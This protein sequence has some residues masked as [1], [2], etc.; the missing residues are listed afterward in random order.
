MKIIYLLNI[1]ILFAACGISKNTYIA[2][3]PNTPMFSK[4]KEISVNTA[5]SPTHIELQGAISA[6]KH[7]GITA[8]RFYGGSNRKSNEL[9]INL[10]TKIKKSFFASTTIGYGNTKINIF[11]SIP[12]F[13]DMDKYNSQINYT[14]WF[15]HPGV[16]IAKETEDITYKLG[17]SIK[18]GFNAVKSYEYN[19]EKMF[20]GRWQYSFIQ[21]AIPQSF[22]T[23][24]PL[25]SFEATQGKFSVGAHLGYTNASPLTVK[26]TDYIP[27]GS[28][29][30]VRESSFKQDLFHWPFISSLYV[31]ISL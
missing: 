8:G 7:I 15:V 13:L 22:C 1:V 26:Q 31:G 5:A 18:Y 21:T 23:I 14:T 2:P 9:G 25:L 16:Y 11:S 4:Q 10:Y 20:V 28:T 3:L 19:L 17:F 12:S 29:I 24:S 27:N 30:F 6:T